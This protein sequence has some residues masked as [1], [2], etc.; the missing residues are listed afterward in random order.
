MHPFAVGRSMTAVRASSVA[1][2]LTAASF[3]AAVPSTAGAADFR[4]WACA[5]GS[6]TQLGK[7][8]WVRGTSASLADVFDTCASTA[9]P[10][11]AFAANARATS[12]WSA[13]GGGWA[14]AA[15]PG[16]RI[17]ALD[18]W[19]SWVVLPSRSSGMIRV[20]ALGNHFPEPNAGL[21]LDRSGLCCSNSAFVHRS[22]GSFG[23]PTENDPRVA[24]AEANHQSFPDLRG[25]EGPGT[26]LVALVAACE[27][28]CSTQDEV[29]RYRVYRIRTTVVDSAAPTGTSS[30][31][32]HGMRIAASAP[33]QNTAA[34]VG[35][36][37][38]EVTLRVDGQVVQR[39]SGGEG[40]ADVDPANGDPLEYNLMKPCPTTLTAPLALTPS[41]LPDNEAHTITAVATDAAGQ[42]TILSLARAALAV[43]AGGYDARNG[44]YNPDLNITA[45]RRGNGSNANATA[46]LALGF[47]R[48]GRTASRRTARYSS[49]PRIRGRVTT[50]DN[51]PIA[52]ARVWRATQ[53]RGGQWRITGRPLITSRTGRVS[54]RLQ[55]RRPSRQV[56]LVYFPTTDNNDSALSPNRALRVRSTTTIH[57]DQG[58]YRNGDTLRF[59]GR[60]T[61]NRLI[62]SKT[63]FLQAMVRGKWRTFK[64]TRAG[65]TGRWRMTHRFEATRR[66]T[67]YTFRAVVP[68]QT[69]YPWATGYSRRVRVL[70][71]P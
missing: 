15:A 59:A 70:V 44:F 45:G 6:G 23:T 36:G 52:G 9:T 28:N 67:V 57:S 22:P 64:T 11:G 42:D 48:G 40:C 30:G 54:A 5:S 2:A 25:P 24:F 8:D 27:N 14:V 69:G 34:D 60:V 38:R 51:R 63:V 13:G 37:V 71:T 32:Q 4:V 39:I 53:T 56:R 43:P 29:A 1:V 55:A 10:T 3:V 16:T 19:W 47:V 41:H 18:L 62:R 58:G 46:R 7:G 20:A 33:I 66:P 68:S 12:A 31:L 35:G 26:P 50:T 61:R 65:S 17:S 49:R 21:D